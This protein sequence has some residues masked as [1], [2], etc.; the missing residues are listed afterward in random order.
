MVGKGSITVFYGQFHHQLDDKGR[1]RIPPAFRKLLGDNPMMFC[2]IENCLYVYTR[3]DFTKNV[4]GRFADSDI[5]DI[6]MNEL[7]RAIFSSTQE[8]TEDKQG[9]TALNPAFIEMCGLTKNVISIGAMDHVEIWDEEE[10][11][12]HR[13]SLDFKKILAQFSGRSVR[14]TEQ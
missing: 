8:L 6:D 7:K 14:K 3:E 10:Y 9:R 12:K 11:K 1:L 2:G 4:E 5:L 13:E